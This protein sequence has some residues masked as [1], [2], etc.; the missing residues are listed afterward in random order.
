MELRAATFA[1]V[2][3]FS[4]LSSRI[5]HL[6]Y[7]CTACGERIEVRCSYPS[8][9]GGERQ[10]TKSSTCYRSMSFP[11]AFL[12]PTYRGPKGAHRRRSRKSGDVFLRRYRSVRRRWSI[13]AQKG[14]SRSGEA[15]EIV[16][17]ILNEWVLKAP[18][19]VSKMYLKTNANMPVHGTDGIHA[20]FD[21]TKKKLYLYWGKF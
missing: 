15:G 8:F 14:S 12:E 11:F 16:L 5:R 1:A 19:I 7:D 9:R 18:Q 6:D 13:K 3:P 10:R 4:H 2:G 21:E 20:R 17:Y